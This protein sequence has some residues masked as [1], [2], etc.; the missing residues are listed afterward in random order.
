LAVRRLCTGIFAASVASHAQAIVIR[1]DREDARYIELAKSYPSACQIIPDGIGTLIAPGWVITAAHVGQD[2]SPFANSV[3]FGTR[4]VRVKEVFLH[5]SWKGAPRPEVSDIALLELEAPV[6]DVE[7][8]AIVREAPTVGEIV[9]FVGC[10]GTGTGQTGPKIT[11]DR[12]RGATNSLDEIAGTRFRFRFD[13]PPDGTDLEGISGPGDSGGPAFVE[14]GGKH[15]VVGISSTN[16]SG[17]GTGPCTYGTIESYANIPAVA[18]W[19]DQTMQSPPKQPERWTKPVKISDRAWP[20]TAAA[21]VARAF[22]DSYNTGTDEAMRLF[23][24]ERR[25]ARE[26]QERSV[27]ARVAYW[28][29]QRKKSATVTPLEFSAAMDGSLCVLVQMADGKQK[30]Y[31]FHLVEGG[32]LESIG[33]YPASAK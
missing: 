18:E 19:I 26:L 7:P 2:L 21:S 33:M 16:H 27:D 30:A 10:G 14:R 11:D 15:A 23:E 25:D 22:F 13:A 5:P 4:E 3:R 31:T 12:W 32:K 17:T 6:A 20:E 8:T 24:S 28:R 1:H 9:T 29:S